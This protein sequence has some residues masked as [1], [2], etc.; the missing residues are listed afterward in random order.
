MLSQISIVMT[1]HNKLTLYEYSFYYDEN[2][3]RWRLPGRVCTVKENEACLDPSPASDQ[4]GSSHCQC[5]HQWIY[6]G[7]SETSSAM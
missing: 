1:I 5:V 6:L 4:D 3:L 2:T 7:G